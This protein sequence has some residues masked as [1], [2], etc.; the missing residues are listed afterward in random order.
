MVVAHTPHVVI[1]SACDGAVWR[2][3]VGMAEYYG[4]TVQV[5]EIDGDE[6]NVLR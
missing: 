5:L 3:D 4:G 1:N 2:V 6:V